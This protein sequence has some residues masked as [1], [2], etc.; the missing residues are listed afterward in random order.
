MHCFGLSWCLV[1]NEKSSVS[2]MDSSCD[3][4][5]FLLQF[6]VPSLLSVY[7]I[8]SII[9]C[10]DFL[11]W[12]HLFHTLCSCVCLVCFSL[13]HGSFLW[14]SS[15]LVYVIDLGVLPSPMS[16]IYLFLFLTLFSLVFEIII[17][18]FC[19]FLSSLKITPMY[20][21]LLFFK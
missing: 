2:L 21:S 13:I 20:I 12:Y 18:S 4:Y 17:S 15:I 11:F 8:L 19:P 3:M 14:S 7:L 6:S 1:S 9:R 10:G 16:F 5:I